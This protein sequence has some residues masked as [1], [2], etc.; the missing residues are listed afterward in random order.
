MAVREWRPCPL[1]SFFLFLRLN[2]PCQT[3]ASTFLSRTPQIL[4]PWDL[5][6]HTTGG[7]AGQAARLATSGLGPVLWTASSSEEGRI[8]STRLW[9]ARLQRVEMVVSTRIRKAAAKITICSNYIN[10]SPFLPEKPRGNDHRTSASCLRQVFLV[11]AAVARLTFSTSTAVPISGSVA[12]G[13]YSSA[14]TTA[15]RGLAHTLSQMLSAEGKKQPS[16]D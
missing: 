13:P 6:N 9:E 16:A 7:G 4:S 1:R 2:R 10:P 8:A 11:R 15:S 5:S 14:I 3:E 12:L